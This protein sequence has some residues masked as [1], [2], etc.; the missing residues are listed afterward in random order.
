MF[1]LRRLKLHRRLRH[2]TFYLGM[3]HLCQLSGKIRRHT[4]LTE[5]DG[6]LLPN[7]YISYRAPLDSQIHDRTQEITMSQLL[8]EFRHDRLHP[9]TC[10]RIW[11]LIAQVLRRSKPYHLPFTQRTAAFHP[12]SGIGQIALYLIERLLLRQAEKR[13]KRVDPVFIRASCQLQQPLFQLLQFLFVRHVLL[14]PP[15]A[16]PVR[17]PSMPRQTAFVLCI[18]EKDT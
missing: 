1:C 4:I 14:P 6:L 7:E 3:P 8:R 13:R 11:L 15:A 18:K 2:G 17:L 16:G 9:K 12:G 10:D 5:H